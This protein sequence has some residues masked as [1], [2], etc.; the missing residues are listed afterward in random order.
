[1]DST[2]AGAPPTDDW[3][4]GD[5]HGAQRAS[6]DRSKG[7]G[8][9]RAKAQ[10]QNLDMLAKIIW[11]DH[12]PQGPRHTEYL[13]QFA[14]PPPPTDAA[15]AA[16]PTCTQDAVDVGGDTMP[17][18]VPGPESA[19]PITFANGLH[20]LR[21]AV[22]LRTAV[23]DPP[24]AMSAPP[25]GTKKRKRA[26]KAEGKV[27]MCIACGVTET[28]KWRCGMTLCNACGLRNAKHV[29][30]GGNDPGASVPPPPARAARQP[31]AQASAPSAASSSSTLPHLVPM[32]ATPHAGS[33]S[34]A[35]P[36][37]A[38]SYAAPLPNAPP[39]DMTWAAAES[40]VVVAEAEESAP[41]AIASLES[42]ESQ[43]P[44]PVSTAELPAQPLPV[45]SGRITPHVV[46]DT[47][48]ASAG[49]C[50]P[51]PPPAIFGMSQTVYT[52]DSAVQT[53]G[54]YAVPMHQP[55]TQANPPQMMQR[56]TQPMGAMPMNPAPQQM[57][58]AQMQPMVPLQM[59]SPM[60]SMT[61]MHIQAAPQMQMNPAPSSW[62]TA[63][64]T[65]AMQ[66]L[67]PLQQP[68]TYVVHP[69]GYVPSQ[70]PGP[71]QMLMQPHQI[72]PHQMQPH[73][74]QPHQ[75]QPHQMQPHPMLP[76][77]MQPHSMQPHP[78]QPYP[79]QQQI[80]Q[81]APHSN[82]A[83]PVFT[84]TRYATSTHLMNHQTQQLSNDI[85]QRSK[86]NAYNNTFLAPLNCPDPQSLDI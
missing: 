16:P 13:S 49:A 54:Q 62:A 5:D 80:S 65:H 18:A 83:A 34:S 61:P 31:K 46:F 56:M 19:E 47:A 64:A 35:M 77:Q 8:K 12:T 38:A 32:L 11:A 76:H 52:C 42:I 29:E 1:M 10:E 44:H 21:A 43:P 51:P 74:M 25:A 50:E 2:S 48:T 71:P 27:L 68:P 24:M 86:P 22:A 84:T 41:M 6:Q 9:S 70:Q 40:R 3:G 37:L 39:L 67:H 55:M 17:G 57:T 28:P 78:M 4:G 58:Q 75:M 79:V 81:P 26:L 53:G 60:Q 7:S 30:H 66:Q 15:T 20:A 45:S 82:T 73:Q 72:Q 85:G 36:P 59:T 14:A 33:N 69:P 63:P 23:A